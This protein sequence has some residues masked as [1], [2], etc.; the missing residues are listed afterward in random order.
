MITGKIARILNEYQLVLNVGSKE[1]VTNG[2]IFIIYEEGEE[3]KDPD[4][5]DSLGNLE[6]VKGEV[7]VSHVQRTICLA[8]SKEKQEKTKP[9]I[10]SAKLA[11]VTPSSKTKLEIKHEKLYVK[12]PDISNLKATGPISVGDL[13]RSVE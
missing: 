12:Q 10:L 8:Q 13:V 2:M 7:E 9:T 1:E 11:E 4:S 5:G 6:M 3:I